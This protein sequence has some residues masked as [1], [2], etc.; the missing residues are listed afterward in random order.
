[1]GTLLLQTIAA[2]IAK[3]ST[4]AKY[5]ALFMFARSSRLKPLSH[6]LACRAVNQL[7]VVHCFDRSAQKAFKPVCVL[8]AVRH[9]LTAACVAENAFASALALLD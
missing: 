1:M 9:D 4:F 8:Y 7:P 6:Q 3:T 2:G 5:P